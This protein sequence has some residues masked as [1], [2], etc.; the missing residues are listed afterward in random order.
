MEWDEQCQE[1]L[2]KIKKY[3]VNPPVLKPPKIGKPLILYLAVEPEA[4][5]AML[6]QEDDTSVEHAVYYLS[7][8]MLPYETRYQKVEN[9]FLVVI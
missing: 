5:G 2:D 8:M 9:I 1:A 4:L 3:L 6:V 7:K